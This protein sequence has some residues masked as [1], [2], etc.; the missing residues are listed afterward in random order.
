MTI[1]LLTL[2]L[3]TYIALN[4][5]A[6]VTYK[7]TGG[8]QLYRVPYNVTNLN[9]YLIGGMGGYYTGEAPDN[10][11]R[12]YPAMVCGNLMVEPGQTSLVAME[13]RAK[14]ASVLATGQDM[15]EAGYQIFEQIPII[16]VQD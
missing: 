1:L 10:T 3:F 7:Y 2:I 8:Y 14:L 11:P 15:V 16:S 5:A 9:V 12:P 13:G 6:I 4:I